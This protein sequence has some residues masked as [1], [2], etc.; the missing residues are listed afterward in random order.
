MGATIPGGTNKVPSFEEYLQWN[1]DTSRLLKIALRNHDSEALAGVYRRIENKYGTIIA[2]KLVYN[3]INHLMETEN[4]SFELP[5][6]S[7]SPL[8]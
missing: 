1:A 3:M 7:P 5:D 2:T 8:I 4:W 6:G